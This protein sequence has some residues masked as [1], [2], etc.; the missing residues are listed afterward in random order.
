MAS[1]KD[2]ITIPLVLL[3]RKWQREFLRGAINL[4][5]KD[6]KTSKTTR[7]VDC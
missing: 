7:Q 6:A 2:K 4:T 5:E 1:T 3:M